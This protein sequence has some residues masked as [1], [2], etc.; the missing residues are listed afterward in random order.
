MVLRILRVWGHEL[1]IYSGGME[2]MEGEGNVL[3]PK[4]M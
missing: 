1:R 4:L 2:M 3:K